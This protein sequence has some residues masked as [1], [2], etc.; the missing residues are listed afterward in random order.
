MCGSS[1]SS[2]AAADDDDTTTTT[3]IIH[4]VIL[5]F[6]CSQNFGHFEATRIF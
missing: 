4:A 5:N 6:S 1:S 3:T 2:A